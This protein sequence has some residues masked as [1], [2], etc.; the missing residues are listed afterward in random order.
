MA[1]A[2]SRKSPKSCGADGDHQRQADGRPDRIAA[3]DPVPE[4]EDAVGAD[5]EGAHLVERRRDRGEVRGHRRL[6][7]MLDDPAPRRL[8]IGHGLDGREGLGGDDHQRGRGIEPRQRIGDMR[9]IHVGDEMQPRPV[10]IGRQRQRRHRRAEIRAADADIDDIGELCAA[11]RRDRPR[12][13]PRGESR[14][15]LQ[16]VIHRRHDVLSVDEDGPVRTIAQRDMQHGA[17]LGRIDRRT[18]E[19]GIALAGEL[20]RPGQAAAAIASCAR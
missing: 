3:A 10:M 2:P 7:E 6:A 19:H 8:R 5:A 1:W 17:I 16:H 15:A 13:Q 20:G 14:H 11:G 18:R 9:A 4:A 12:A